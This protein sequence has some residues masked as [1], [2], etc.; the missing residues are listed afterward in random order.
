MKSLEISDNVFRQA[1]PWIFFTSWFEFVLEQVRWIETWKNDCIKKTGFTQWEFESRFVKQIHFL[2]FAFR[3]E[4][5]SSK[6]IRQ[7]RVVSE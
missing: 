1:N 6:N 4:Y 5:L 7:Y 3:S 2:H